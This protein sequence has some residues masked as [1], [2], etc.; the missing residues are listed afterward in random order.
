MARAELLDSPV[1]SKSQIATV[2]DDPDKVWDDG[3]LLEL[4]RLLGGEMFLGRLVD[5]LM[6]IALEVAGAERGLLLMSRGDD[7]RLVGEAM[8]TRE[9][10]SV[11]PLAHVPTS[12]DLPLSILDHVMRRRERVLVEGDVGRSAFAADAYLAHASAGS[13]LC[14]PLVKQ[15]ALTGVL[16][17]ER[18]RSS[19]F[20]P[21]RVTAV[22]ELAVQAAVSLEN[23]SLYTQLCQTEVYLAKA[24]E[25]SRT[26]SFGW[27]A[28]TG[29]IF[30]SAETYRIYGFE[31]ASPL[32]RDLIHSRIHPDDREQVEKTLDRYSDTDGWTV[33]Y[34]I[35]MQDGS[36]KHLRVAAHGTRVGFT[37]ELNFLGAVMDITEATRSQQA[38]ERAFHEIQKL[39]DQ[40]EEENVALREEIDKTSMFEEIVGTSASL[41]AVLSHVAKVAP[42]DSTVLITGESGTGKEL[43]ARAIHRRSERATRP[44]V[45]V[46]CAAVPPGLIASELFGHEK[47]AF[48]GASELRLGRFELANGGTLFLDEIG[49]LPNETQVALLRVLQERE[50]ERVGG[51]RRIPST[52][53][54]IAATHRDLAAA[55]AEK[56]FRA[57]LFYRVNVFPLEVPPL[58]D[59]REDIPLLVEY[60]IDRYGRRAGKRIRGIGKNGLELLTAYD[61]PG[62]IRELQNIIERAVILCDTG[63][64]QIDERW[65]A[66]QPGR[67]PAPATLSVSLTDRERESIETILA[68][69]KGRVS[70]PFGAAAKL[71]LPAS[72][73]ES[74]IKALG[75]DKRRFKQA[76]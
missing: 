76:R 3:E 47:G 2:L 60:F 71:G 32:S 16:Y 37:G 17:L 45:S 34:R 42:T 1:V 70:G 26:G 11:R 9:G 18:L 7:V 55:V 29:E 50:F 67:V 72:T 53:R 4:S 75:I 66:V 38:L 13:V 10:T 15:N 19:G 41:R 12:T 14:L 43:V 23:A 36:V 21:A 28:T 62:N 54:V 30:W 39:K 69:T 20:T 59:R 56:S 40:L 8:N 64:L 44:F 33:E 24:Q 49:E 6:R 52:A 5:K 35:V 22:T 27:R 58:R 48:T 57:D 74:K 25:L 68:D 46:N 51:I 61:W 65:L 73:L 63:T 31:P